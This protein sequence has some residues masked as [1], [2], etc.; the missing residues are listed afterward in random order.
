MK[1]DEVRSKRKNDE[2]L[3]ARRQKLA[4][5]YNDEMEQWKE[6]VLSMVETQEDRKKR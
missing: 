4:A 6:E 5:V 2:L 1:D 3:H